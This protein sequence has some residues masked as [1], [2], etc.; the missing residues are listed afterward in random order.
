[1]ITEHRNTT[2]RMPQT[3][4]CPPF[5]NVYFETLDTMVPYFV[6]ASLSAALAIPTTFANLVVL[7]A[8]RYVTSVR[9]PSKL[10]LCSL[11][12][13]D[14]GAGLV[15][16]PQRAALFFMKGSH[17]PLCSLTFSYEF[18]AYMFSLATLF[19]LTA[20]SIDRYAALFF[21]L[22]YQGVVT[23]RRVCVVLTFIWL[24]SLMFASPT[25]WN[26]PVSL[27]IATVSLFLGFIVIS[28]A[29]IKIY[30]RLRAGPQVQ[31]HNQ[32]QQEAGTSLNME[33]YRRTAFAMMWVY[34]L[35][36]ICYMPHVSVFA[37]STTTFTP[38]IQCV[39]DFT[40]TLLLLNS[41][42]NPFVYCLRL[43][44]VRGEVIKQ[45]RTFCCRSS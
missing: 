24:L 9:L 19:N 8:M 35:F 16:L 36:V 29:Y 14:L 38:L 31:P 43:P 21:Q 18:N 4:F 6:N 23:T 5:P 22:K 13:T 32:V 20:M 37:V 42:L 39:R 11:V 44:E 10:L 33:R 45:L 25:L 40:Y 28:V 34:V 15:V 7:W 2:T 1:M 41:F 3:L 30:R 17:P 12:L 26:F 27:G